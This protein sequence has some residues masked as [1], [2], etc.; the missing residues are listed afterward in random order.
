[1]NLLPNSRGLFFCHIVNQLIQYT[2]EV[3]FYSNCWTSYPKAE[4]LS[5]VVLRSIRCLI[6]EVGGV[7]LPW[8]VKSIGS[9]VLFGYPDTVHNQHCVD[10]GEPSEIVSYPATG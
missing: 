8:L 4:L 6:S 3:E 2:Q 10:N 1:M 7:A 9:R 5:E